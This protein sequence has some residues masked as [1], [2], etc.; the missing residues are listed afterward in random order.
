MGFLKRETPA[1]PEGLAGVGWEVHLIPIVDTSWWYWSLYEDG[2]IVCDRAITVGRQEA[3]TAA[4]ELRDRITR[5]RTDVN[6]STVVK[7]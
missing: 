5:R 6:L 7:I 1:L 4:S 3:L 2:Q